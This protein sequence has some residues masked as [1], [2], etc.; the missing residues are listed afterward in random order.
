MAR[1]REESARDGRVLHYLSHQ[2]THSRASGQEAEAHA[3]RQRGVVSPHQHRAK[4]QLMM[5]MTSILSL[6]LSSVPIQLRD[7]S[8]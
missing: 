6:V 4:E 5:E 2:A 1:V 7:V 8:K 3:L